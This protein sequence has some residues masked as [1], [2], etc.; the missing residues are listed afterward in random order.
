MRIA[1]I[2]EHASPLAQPGGVDCGGQN[3][4]V[5]QVGRCLAQAGHQVDVF[6]R[7]DAPAQRPVVDLRPG[8]RVLHV[9]AGPAS[10]VAKERL[11]EHM[12]QF[13][14]QAERAVAASRRYDVIHANFFMSGWVG[15]RLQRRFGLPLVTTFHALGRVRRLHQGGSDVFPED[16]LAI[17]DRLV[18]RSD[19][20]IAECPQDKKDLVELYRASP[21][22]IHSVPCGVDTE[23]FRPLGKGASRAA[24]GLPNDAFIVLQLGRLVARKG[25]DNVIRAVARLD[26]ALRPRLYVVGG[27]GPCPD[28]QRDPEIARLRGVAAECGAG[29]RVHFVG[30]RGGDDLA[31]WYSAADVFVTTPWYEPFGI[32]PLEAMACATPVVGS[33][34]GG[35]QHS[36]VDGRTGYLVPPKDDAA[37]AERLDLLARRPLHARTLGAAGLKRVR[38]NFTWEQVAS[39]LLEVFRWVR[40]ARRRPADAQPRLGTLPSLHL[41]PGAAFERVHALGSST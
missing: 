6:T 21:G 39:E 28:E 3:V 5:A 41:V 30:A 22:Q 18:Q 11:L 19:A 35:I 38:A 31:R 10:F 32:T 37:L 36:V 20:V 26:A 17:E 23:R 4:Y 13:A 24:L 33:R 16:R 34:V 14:R 25:I 1:M 40:L 29:D 27:S 12:P 15:M 8:L 2:S 7:R 9:D